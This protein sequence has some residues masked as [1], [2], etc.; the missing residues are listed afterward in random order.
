MSVLAVLVIAVIWLGYSGRIAF[1]TLDRSL[2]IQVNGT[3]VPGEILSNKV[4]AIV[5]RRDAGK[6]HSYQLFFEG[7]TD[8][9][10]DMGS[11]VDCHDWVAPQ[12]PLLL[13][14]RNYPPCKPLPE[15][16]PGLRRWPFIRQGGSMQFV[17]KDQS[18]ISVRR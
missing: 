9:T 1:L 15:D 2:T 11:V 14:T 16:Q 3:V 17:T 8:S 4:T 10:G 13:V 18:T 6:R 5:T 12:L 7:D